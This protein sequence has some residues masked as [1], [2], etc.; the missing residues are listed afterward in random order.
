MRYAV[1]LVMFLG[2][3]AGTQ[4]AT[5]GER[6]YKFA[7]DG[8]HA[9]ALRL[10]GQALAEAQARDDIPAQARY[11]VNMALILMEQGNFEQAHNLTELSISVYRRLGDGEGLGMCYLALAKELLAR[12][13]LDSALAAVD[14]AKILFKAAK[15]KAAMEL[16]ENERGMI[17]LASGKPDSAAVIFERSAKEN[18]KKKRYKASA[19]NLNNLGRA[20]MLKLDWSTARDYLNQAVSMDEKSGSPAGK[21]V[22]LVHLSYVSAMV[23][24]CSDAMF[25]LNRAASLG[26]PEFLQAEVEQIRQHCPA[27][28]SK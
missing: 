10:Y 17:F 26:I 6:A 28:L 5:S 18:R 15:K 25:Y 16:A 2:F 20:Y 21:C 23:G 19:S 22:P 3:L 9:E 24:N 4:A 1:A 14:S 13:M 8:R 11:R 12:K 27:P 7:A